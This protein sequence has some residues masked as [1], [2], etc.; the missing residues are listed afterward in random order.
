MVEADESQGTSHCRGE[1]QGTE[2]QVAE[3][4]ERMASAIP[5]FM[6]DNAHSTVPA[7]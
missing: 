1:S 2:S 6:A 5:T 3:S 7:Q 4:A